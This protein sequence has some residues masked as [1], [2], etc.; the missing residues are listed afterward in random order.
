[1]ST[2]SESTESENHLNSGDVERVLDENTEQTELP[3]LN[4]NVEDCHVATNEFDTSPH[5]EEEK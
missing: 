5:E 4:C 2:E 3:S 1:M